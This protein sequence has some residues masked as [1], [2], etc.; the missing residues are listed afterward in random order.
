MARAAFLEAQIQQVIEKL[1]SHEKEDIASY[2]RNQF[3]ELRRQVTDF[4]N[5]HIMT[6]MTAIAKETNAFEARIA[7]ELRRIYEQI[8]KTKKLLTEAFIGKEK[9]IIFRFTVIY[10]KY[11]KIY[12]FF[13]LFH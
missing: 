2:L 10:G 6:H 7:E 12:I 11:L 9:N 13:D 5:E 1:T 4:K 8:W 3:N